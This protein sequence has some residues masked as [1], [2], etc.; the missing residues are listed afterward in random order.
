[1]INYHNYNDCIDAITEDDESALNYIGDEIKTQEFY[2]AVSKKNYR[3]F[4]YVT[5][6]TPELCL[7]MVKLYGYKV[8]KYFPDYIKTDYFYLKACFINNTIIKDLPLE[9][10]SEELY[11]EIQN[12]KT[13]TTLN[14]EYYLFL[15]KKK[16]NSNQ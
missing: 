13:N 3:L 5:H 16:K 6:K 7:K 9:L 12:L 2:L 10:I 8:F 11:K 15:I 1:M 14:E 4:R